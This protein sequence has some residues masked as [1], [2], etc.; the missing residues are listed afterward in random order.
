MKHKNKGKGIITVT[1]DE[2]VHHIFHPGKII[3]LN[4]EYHKF[5]KYGVYPI[6][7]KN[8]KKTKKK[9]DD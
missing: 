1:D 5:E 4:R 8:T 7:Q 3:T 6:E 9:G 2:G